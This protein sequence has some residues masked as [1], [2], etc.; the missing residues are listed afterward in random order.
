[1]KRILI[2]GYVLIIIGGVML[3]LSIGEMAAGLLLLAYYP[4]YNNK[5]K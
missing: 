4:I 5:R 2:I 1:M 3:G